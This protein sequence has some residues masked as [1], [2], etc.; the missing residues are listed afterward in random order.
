[1][2]IALGLDYTH[3]DVGTRE[4]FHLGDAEVEAAYG[5]TSPSGTIREF[6]ALNTCNRVELYGWTNAFGAM[7]PH[8]EMAQRYYGRTPEAERF[9][10]AATQRVGRQAIEHLFRVTSGLESQILGDIHIIGQLRTAYRQAAEL[11]S[12]GP[13]LHRLLDTAIRCGKAVKTET[14]LMVGR[15]SVGSEAATSVLRRVGHLERPRIVV[16]G[17]G[18]IGSHAVESLVKQGAA[19]VTVLNRTESRARALAESAG[20][21]WGEWSTF[22]RTLHEV[23]AVIVATGAASPIVRPEH[24]RDRPESAGPVLLVDISMPRNVDPLVR[25]LD[26]VHL[27]DLDQ[28]HPEAA[29]VARSRQAAVPEA[30]RLVSQHAVEF[31]DW[32]AQHGAREALRPL[33]ERLLEICLREIEH[34]AGKHADAERA[35][36]RIVSKLMAHPMTVLREHGSSGDTAALTGALRTLFSRENPEI[37]ERT[38]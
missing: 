8:L 6:L 9:A 10:S 1:M 16:I 25:P 4:S 28:L 17:A 32:V 38:N 13:N 20:C 7:D 3:A 18:K 35:A 12:M 26:R 31:L 33:R 36:S 37:P 21:A 11:G 30:E 27:V 5:R 34:A 15:S 2:L 29:D 24:L 23:D 22:E 19:D 14:E